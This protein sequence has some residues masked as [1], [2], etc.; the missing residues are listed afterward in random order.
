MPYSYQNPSDIFMVTAEVYLISR[1]ANNAEALPADFDTVDPVATIDE[2]G[3]SIKMEREEK[4]FKGQNE[5][6]PLSSKG[7]ALID[8]AV[9]ENSNGILALITGRDSDGTGVMDTTKVTGYECVDIWEKG[10]KK[11]YAA[12]IKGQTSDGMDVGF[13]FHN[14]TAASQEFPPFKGETEPS[15]GITLTAD[16]NGGGSPGYRFKQTA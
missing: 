9:G 3:V 16:M 11:Q 12:M 13:I 5:D 14:V 8:F 4:V 2:G 10:A 7:K 1:K 15:L 6:I